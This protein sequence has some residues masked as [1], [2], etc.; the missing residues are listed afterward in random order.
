MQLLQDKFT[1]EA[2]LA[3]S[4][5]RLK[6]ELE[7]DRLLW[8][9]TPHVKLPVKSR[10]AYDRRSPSEILDD[11]NVACPLYDTEEKGFWRWR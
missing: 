2:V 7:E 1:P 3:T 6:H 8:G 10:Y 4:G 11:F 9:K 5:I